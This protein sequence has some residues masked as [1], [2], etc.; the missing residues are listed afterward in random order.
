MFIRCAFFRGRAKP[1]FEDQ[2]TA[3][4]RNK[5]VPLWTRFPGAEEVRVWRQEES[6]TNDPHF[7]MVLQVRYP[8]KQAIEAALASDVRYESREVTKGLLEMF[9]GNIFH[10]VFRAD[11]YALPTD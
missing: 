6:D 7:E 2:F 4:V 1:G 3:Y 11:D 5:L 9:E 10:T 8:S